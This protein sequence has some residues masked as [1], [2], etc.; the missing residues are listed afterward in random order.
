[1]TNHH[2]LFD[3]DISGKGQLQE[4]FHGSA[5]IAAFL[6]VKKHSAFTALTGQLIKNKFKIC[7]NSGEQKIPDESDTHSQTCNIIGSH[8]LIQAKY[9]RR[10][11]VIFLT[12]GKCTLTGIII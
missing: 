8:L 5:D 11:K 1:M 6:P 12:N 2:N 3:Y 10:R 7:W 9:Y 4:F